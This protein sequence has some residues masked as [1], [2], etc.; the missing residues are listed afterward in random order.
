[1]SSRTISSAPDWLWRFASSAGSPSSRRPTNWT[2]LT[3][4]PSSTSRQAM[5]RLVSMSEYRE[6]GEQPQSGLAG[7][8]RMKLHAEKQV[9]LDGGR[10][11]SSVFTAGHGSAV[12]GCMIGVGKVDKRRW[13]QAAEQAGR[14]C[15]FQLIPADM[16]RFDGGRKAGTCAGEQA[17]AG[18]CRGFLAAGEHPLHSD[19]DAEE[20]N[21]ALDGFRD[22]GFEPRVGQ[23]RGCDEV[24]YSRKNNA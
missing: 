2:P 3:T 7:F 17:Q 19:A 8:F 22:G 13:R 14:G 21:L 24:A 11:P 4:R 20:G 6:V 10:E 5:I 23:S 1:M 18:G 9:A 15:D 12:E 16:G